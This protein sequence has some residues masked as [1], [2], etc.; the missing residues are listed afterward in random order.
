MTTLTSP[1]TERAGSQPGTS[2][3]GA[4]IDSFRLGGGLKVTSAHKLSSDW[5]LIPHGSVSY[6]REFNPNARTL[7]AIQAGAPVSL[8]TAPTGANIFDLGA[9][10]TLKSTQGVKVSANYNATFKKAYLGQTG[11]LRFTYQF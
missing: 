9:A 11:S 1:Y 7:E 2:L 6:T 3:G 4:R 8:R 5:A 10:A